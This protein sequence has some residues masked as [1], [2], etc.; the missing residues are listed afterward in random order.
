MPCPDSPD[1][2]EC[3]VDWR[4]VPNKGTH[5]LECKFDCRSVPD[6]GTR[7]LECKLACSSVHDRE[8]YSLECKLACRSVPDRGTCS[9]EHKLAVRNCISQLVQLSARISADQHDRQLRCLHANS[10]QWKCSVDRE[11]C[12]Q[13]EVEE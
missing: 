2:L 9:L 5:T 10:V 8:T 6:K 3:K 13:Q 7:M 11:L 4:S 1:S 12:T